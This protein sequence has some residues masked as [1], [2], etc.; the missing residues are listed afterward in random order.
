MAE[1]KI[2]TVEQLLEKM[3]DNGDC[4]REFEVALTDYVGAQEDDASLKKLLA[5]PETAQRYLGVYGM[6]IYYRRLMQYDDM[7]ALLQ[8]H[9]KDFSDY[10]SLGHLET[11]YHIDS[12]EYYTPD[13]M[14][15]HI[16]QAHKVAEDYLKVDNVSNKANVAGTQHAFAD[17]LI[18]FCERYEDQQESLLQKWGRTAKN[19]LEKAIGRSPTYAKY[20]CTKGRLLA[21]ENDYANALD[22]VRKAI[23]METPTGNASSYSLRIMQYQSH[24]VRIQARSE[25][26]R[27]NVQQARMNEE[28]DKM[29][30]SLMNNVE[31]I[32]FFSGVISFVIGS[33]SLAEGATPRGAAGLIVILLGALLVVFNCFSLLLHTETKNLPVRIAVFVVGVVCVAGG[34]LFVL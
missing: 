27:L 26:H 34:L 24:M 7:E 14:E 8:K 10:V 9:K 28:V 32:A 25:I 19:A 13:E 4:T 1:Q 6:C 11:L 29:R 23:R 21:L 33:L 16:R 17:L 2:L 20:H 12:G 5:S 22:S 18:T 3:K 31:I 30:S 15:R